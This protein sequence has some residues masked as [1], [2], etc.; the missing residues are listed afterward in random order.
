MTAAT[1]ATDLVVALLLRAY[2][3]RIT[4]PAIR[5]SDSA[6]ALFFLFVHNSCHCYRF[7]SRISARDKRLPVERD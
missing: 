1:T 5:A 3:A 2:D 7:R 4:T 6:I